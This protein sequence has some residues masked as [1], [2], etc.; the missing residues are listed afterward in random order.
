MMSLVARL[1]DSLTAPLRRLRWAVA[2]WSPSRDRDFHDELFRGKTYDPLSPSYPGYLTI[3]RFADHAEQHFSEVQVAIDLGCGPGEITCEL[4][5]RRPDVRFIGIDHSEVALER[6]CALA[7]RIGISNV[8]FERGDLETYTPNGPVDLVMMF[9]AFHHILAPAAF[10]TRVSQR[11]D[12]FFLV[13]PAGTWSGSWSRRGD[14]DWLALTIGQIRQRL[15]YQFGVDAHASDATREAAAPPAASPAEAEPTEHRYTKGD[16]ERIFSGYQLELR[17]T[18]AGLDAYGDRPHVVSPLRD[19][20][21]DLAYQMVR[22]VEDIL[23]EEGLDLAAKHWTIYASRRGDARVRDDSRIRHLRPV[24]TAASPAYG[25]VYGSVAAP[26][27][28]SQGEVFN[29][30][31]NVTN[32]GW[33]EW[34]SQDASPVFLSYH[35]QDRTGR[36]V[37]RDG[38]RSAL[39]AV[40]AQ[41]QQAHATVRVQAP[42]DV[43][44][45]VLA[46]DLVHEGVA[47]FSDHGV[48]P[49]TV[50][51]RIRQSAARL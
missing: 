8:V 30:T 50:M 46:I 1:S 47:W 6:A 38:F 42:E 45:L 22:G 34:N 13:E 11:C 20:F 43:D 39:P 12:R 29:A 27:V 35:W 26:S 24:G 9:D 33:I 16:L 7:Q 4:A 3:R 17:G 23:F 44:D 25:A 51:V 14:L 31:V 10:V 32:T 15:E 2:N 41:G 48:G 21:G 19:R 18:I 5:R 36:T 28:A 49:A 37:V 40:L